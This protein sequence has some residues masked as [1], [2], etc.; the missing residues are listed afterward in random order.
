MSA[1]DKPRSGMFWGL[2]GDLALSTILKQ[3]RLTDGETESPLKNTVNLAHPQRVPSWGLFGHS[4]PSRY[5]NGTDRMI[6]F[7]GDRTSHFPL[8]G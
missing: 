8:S 1:S 5:P 7:S 2:T 3:T 6:A 4:S